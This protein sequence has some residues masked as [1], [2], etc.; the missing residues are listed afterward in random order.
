[1]PMRI[2][3]PRKALISHAVILFHLANFSSPITS[4]AYLLL[5]STSTL[6]RSEL[7]KSSKISRGEVGRV[8]VGPA[9][10]VIGKGLMV[11][12]VRLEDHEVG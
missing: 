6:T 2:E 3:N 11:T 10:D 5:S 12:C 8:S 7:K 9:S 4:L 1:M